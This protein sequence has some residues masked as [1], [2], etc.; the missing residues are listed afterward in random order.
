MTGAFDDL[1]LDA[2]VRRELLRGTRPAMPDRGGAY[3]RP[4]DPLAADAIDAMDDATY[5]SQ[6]DDE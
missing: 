5:Q 6:E 2:L 3:L 1:K 4:H